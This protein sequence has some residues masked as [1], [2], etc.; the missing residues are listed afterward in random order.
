ML[1]YLE[2]CNGKFDLCED[3]KLCKIGHDTIAD[4]YAEYNGGDVGGFK[5][6]NGVAVQRF[7]N[8]LSNRVENK[9]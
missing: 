7:V 4:E 6:N 8:A 2:C 3:E 9:C 1:A 5:S